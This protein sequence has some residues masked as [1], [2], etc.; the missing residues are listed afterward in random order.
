MS[1]YSARYQVASKR[2]AAAQFAETAGGVRRGQGMKLHGCDLRLRIFGRRREWTIA[3]ARRRSSNSR[4]I[5]Q[6]AS[7]GASILDDKAWP[8]SRRP[9]FSSVAMARRSEVVRGVP[10]AVRP[11]KPSNSMNFHKKDGRWIRSRSAEIKSNTDGM[12]F[13]LLRNAEAV[14]IKSA[15]T[16]LSCWFT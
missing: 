13:S 11:R 8:I 14:W 1:G 4:R 5:S 15:A 10:G 6:A 12:V 7:S 9:A 3:L 2:A 16:V